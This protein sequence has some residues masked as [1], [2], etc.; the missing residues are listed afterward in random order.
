MRFLVL[1]L[2]FLA[3]CGRQTLDV[4]ID[5]DEYPWAAEAI[6]AA[7]VDTYPPLFQLVNRDGVT[8]SID[9]DVCGSYDLAFNTITIGDCGLK[10][11]EYRDMTTI[12][13][14]V[15]LHELGHALGLDHSNDKKDLMYPTY[16]RWWKLPECVDSLHQALKVG[17]Y[18]KTVILPPNAP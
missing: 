16:A 4:A 3:A 2:V 8:L 12:H 10:D 18:S 6:A 13:Q 15:L 14:C 11:T 9:V 17:R 1:L 5:P 7:N